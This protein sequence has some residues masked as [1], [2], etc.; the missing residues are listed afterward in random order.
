MVRASPPILS[1]THGIHKAAILVYWTWFTSS[2]HASS[3]Q[4]LLHQRR[5]RSDSSTAMPWVYRIYATGNCINRTGS[6]PP[7]IVST[8]P[9]LLNWRLCLP[10]RI[11]FTDDRVHRTGLASLSPSCASPKMPSRSRRTPRPRRP[12]R[13]TVGTLARFLAIIFFIARC[14][15]Y[16]GILHRELLGCD[17]VSAF[18]F[19]I[20]SFY[21]HTPRIVMSCLCVPGSS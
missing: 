4:D 12:R 15:L 19:A 2:T 11:Y 21:P 8:K 3:L 7:K 14:N 17:L 9:D 10:P 6:T 18:A 20:S 1:A 16:V 13:S 5:W